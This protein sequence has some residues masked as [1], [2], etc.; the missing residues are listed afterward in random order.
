MFPQNAV[1][2]I[3]SKTAFNFV[4]SSPYVVSEI[5]HTLMILISETT[6]LNNMILQG[7]ITI[8]ELTYLPEFQ[9][10]DMLGGQYKIFSF[11]KT[12]FLIQIC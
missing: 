9:P 2:Y 7:T 3:K 10:N 11:E 4:Q 5:S 6:C 8:W 12:N 1:L